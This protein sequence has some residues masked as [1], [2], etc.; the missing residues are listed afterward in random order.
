MSPTVVAT[1]G[2]PPHL[3][4]MG[5]AAATATA[6]GG[7]GGA[8]TLHRP[9]EAAAVPPAQ[10]QRPADEDA[11]NDDKSADHASCSH[12]MNGALK[13][14]HAQQ[15]LESEAMMTAKTATTADG[16][17][18]H[19]MPLP[20]RLAPKITQP[21]QT[22]PFPIRGK[23]AG[24]GVVWVVVCVFVCVSGLCVCESVCAHAGLFECTE[25]ERNYNADDDDGIVRR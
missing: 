8:S 7:G 13:A 14:A 17:E 4:L 9:A 1:P 3:L 24:C 20:P 12:T 22:K 18:A 16:E 11:T 5:G 2:Q 25:H 6:H 15:Q 19:T 21:I 23:W 10:A